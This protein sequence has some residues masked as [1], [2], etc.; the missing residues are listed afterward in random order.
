[1]RGLLL[2]GLLAWT[3]TAHAS[4]AWDKLWHT[5]DQRGEQLLRQGKAADASRTFHDPRRKAYAELRAGNYRRAAQ[6]FSAFDDSDG[7]YNRGN[8]LARS[9]RLQEAIQAYDAALA[10]D[11]NNRD[12]RHNRDLVA[13]ELQKQPPKPQSSSGNGK[14]DDKGQTGKKPKTGKQNGGAAKPDSQNTNGSSQQGQSG[15]NRNKGA[16]AKPAGQGQQQQVR[17]NR[18]T[19]AGQNENANGQ[20]KTSAVVAQ[21]RRDVAAGLD[22]LPK[23]HEAAPPDTPV[24][25]Q[26]LAQQQWL[27]RIPDDPG[28]LLRRKFLIEHMIRQQEGQQ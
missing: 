22:K 24:S 8:A 21:A 14:Q 6:D 17:K 20:F 12:A 7:Q 11:P 4:T 16:N 9:G 26:Q 15:Q 5:P 25:E 1:M 19:Q 10:H 2:A 28:G 27:R 18:A 23:E 3:A 13:K